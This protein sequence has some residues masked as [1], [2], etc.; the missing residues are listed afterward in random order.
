[1][2]DVDVDPAE[3]VAPDGSLLPTNAIVN[4]EK[5]AY[6]VSRDATLPNHTATIYVYRYGTNVVATV[7][8]RLLH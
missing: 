8:D 3:P 1:M 2:L 7:A 5:T 6:R 4:F